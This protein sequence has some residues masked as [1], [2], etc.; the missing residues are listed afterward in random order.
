MIIRFSS[1]YFKLFHFFLFFQYRSYHLHIHFYK[2][3]AILT[4]IV[5]IIAIIGLILGS[6]AL[7]N[8]LKNTEKQQNNIA[9]TN[10]S[11]QNIPK[12]RQ[13]ASGA[14]G[15]PGP[16]GMQGPPGGTFQYR[17]ILRNLKYTDLVSDRFFNNSAPYL[18]KQ[19]YSTSQLWTLNSQNFLQNQYKGCLMAD[20]TTGTITMDTCDGSPASKNWTYSPEGLLRL[21]NTNKCLSISAQNLPNGTK[22]IQNGGQPANPATANMPLFTLIDCET[23][24]NIPEEQRWSFI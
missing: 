9:Q 2:M 10:Q 7:H 1:N 21:N 13:G 5:A 3:L 15:P 14:Q 11:L 24:N 23:S 6:I 19:N 22:V 12:C 18:T 4:S 20:S 17:G 16:Q 8:S